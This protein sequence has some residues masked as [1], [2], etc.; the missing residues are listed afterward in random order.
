MEEV[1]INDKENDNDNSN[2]SA[3][4]DNSGIE[5]DTKYI[6]FIESHNSSQE[7]KV[8]LSP[9]YQEANSLKCVEELELDKDTD[10]YITSIYRFKIYNLI[11]ENEILKIIAED[12]NQEKIEVELSKLKPEKNVFLFDLNSNLNIYD[13]KLNV[14]EELDIYDNYLRNNLELE[15]DSKEY[16]DLITSVLNYI[17]DNNNNKIDFSFYISILLVTFNTQY[18]IDLLELFCYERIREQNEIPSKYIDEF[19]MNINIFENDVFIKSIEDKNKNE[20]LTINLCTIIYYFC[21]KYNKKKI[22]SFVKKENSMYIYK[23]LIKHRKFFLKVKLSKKII[24]S[25]IKNVNSYND[26]F[27]A[28]SYNRDCLT[29]LELINENIDSCNELLTREKDSL[30]RLDLLIEPKREDDLKKI[31]DEILDLYSNEKKF[32]KKF[33]K[34]SP[35]IFDKYISFFMDDNEKINLLNKMINDVKVTEQDF[36]IKNDL[37]FITHEKNIELAKEHKLNNFEILNIIKN[38]KFYNDDQYNSEKFRSPEILSGIDVYQINQEFIAKWKEIDFVKIFDINYY[39]YAKQICKLIPNISYFGLLFELL[40]KGKQNEFYKFDYNSISLMQYTFETLLYTYIPENCLN[41]KNDVINLIYYSDQVKFKINKLL[42]EEIEL[43][44]NSN[45]ISEIYSIVLQRHETL[46]IETL[47]IILEYFTQNNWNTNYANIMNLI[48]LS[49]KIKK[50]MLDKLDKYIIQENE[51]FEIEET[52]N[53]KLLLELIKIYNENK[54]EGGKYFEKTMIVISEL[55]EKIKNLDI[56]YNLITYFIDNKKED[57]LYDRL[58]TIFLL[59]K[60]DADEQKELLIK[61][62]K[63]IKLALNNLQTYLDKVSLF[64]PN[65]YFIEIRDL[66]EVINK[67]KLGTIKK[68]LKEYSYEYNKYTTKL[69][70]DI[71]RIGKCSESYF[72][73]TIYNDVKNKYKLDDEKCFKKAIKHFE[74]LKDI[75]SKNKLE[76]SNE[77]IVENCLKAFIDKEEELKKEI[78]IDIEL[79]KLTSIKDKFRLHQ[80][81]L[82]LLKRKKILDLINS[83]QLFISQLGLIRTDFSK[84]LDNI[85]KK[86][87]LNK[88]KNIKKATDILAKY[89][90]KIEDKLE[91]YLNI[92]LLFKEERSSLDFLF[93]TSIQDCQVLQEL[94]GVFD[95]GFL[96]PDDIINLE[97]CINFMAKFGNIQT[98]RAIKDIDM[99]NKFKNEISKQKNISVYFTKYINNFPLLNDMMT[100]GLDRAEMSKNKVSLIL[101]KSEFTITNKKDKFFN[102]LYFEK[103][104]NIQNDL[105]PSNLKLKDLF[106]LR[107]RAQL[108]R[109]MIIQEKDNAQEKE[110]AILGNQKFI[111]LVSEINNLYG[112]LQDI[113]WKGF[114][115][116]VIVRINID[117]NN[118]IYNV[119]NK[120]YSSFDEIIKIIK[121]IL[122]KINEEQILGYKNKKLIRYFFGLQF[123][124]FYKII[125]EPRQKH[126]NELMPF[127]KYCT[128]E[129][130]IDNL[131]SFSYK[132]SKNIYKDIISNCERYLK[133]ILKKNEITFQKIYSFSIIYQKAKLGKYKGI[134]TYLS[135][136]LEKDLFQ[137]YK[138]FTKRDPVA[139][140]ILLCNKDTTSE[141]IIA[142]LYRAI[143]CEFNSCFIMGGVESLIFE[144]KTNFFN[145]ISSLYVENYRKMRSCLI[146]LYTNKTSD[147]YKWLDLERT[148]KKL[149]ISKEAY[150]NER[151]EGNEIEII[152][153]DR[154]GVGKSAQI[155]N[156]ILIKGKKYV[157]FPL[158]GVLI[159]DQILSRLKKLELD[160]NCVVH[161]DLYDTDQISLMMEFLFSVLVTKLYGKNENIFY[162]SKFLEVKIEIP[163]SFIDF[164]A[165]FPILNLFKKKMLSIDNLAPLIVSQELTSNIQIVCNYLKELKEYNINKR[166]LFFPGITPEIVKETIFIGKKDAKT[167]FV[168]AVDATVLSQNE[169]QRLIFDIIKTRIEK[170]T[171]YQINSFIDILAEQLRKFNQNYYLSSRQLRIAKIPNI[172]KFILESFINITKH[173]TEGAFTELLKRQ[174]QTHKVITGQYNEEQ[175]INDAINNLALNNNN[176]NIVSFDK[177]DPSLLFFHEGE[178]QSFSIITN[179]NKT[180]KEYIDLLALQNSQARIKKDLLKELPNYKNYTQKQ[181]LEELKAIL[182]IKNPVEK[183]SSDKRKSLE[184]I[185]GN[186]VFTADNFVKMALILLRIRS[187]IPV[188]MMGETGC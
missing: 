3:I 25:M 143:L 79:L 102:C 166:D 170:P 177:I 64:F 153:S 45:L 107:D 164:F 117:N 17:H 56:N 73:I 93:Y 20:Q 41:F 59:D 111:K 48:K 139:Q 28:I 175:D 75:F 136:N 67:I 97:N 88:V 145:L 85:V 58:F 44:L 57:L 161:L 21:Y 154:S 31:Y 108:N 116:E 101:E 5:E 174:E 130:I 26:L 9:N 112:L 119:D 128:N 134:Y 104:R 4:S 110:N 94:P 168:T 70:E 91:D 181:F 49:P 36:E 81:L 66:R 63:V 37:E 42:K 129:L 23:G 109:T 121:D 151:Y 39:E 90:I 27:K 43:N 18:F 141:E 146:I 126:L 173:F 171:Y 16:E 89:E 142:F 114:T 138:Y 106:D 52:N 50:L 156:D 188:I 51:F 14:Y 32:N 186:Y 34:M 24:S 71:E 178:G 68:Y 10:I 172:R 15:K 159:R 185:A 169:C 120:T 158:G 30:I 13:S 8:Y 144:K 22:K 118:I 62:V 115:N 6:F 87:Q 157:Y 19:N 149:D 60:Y 140:N 113:Y 2:N 122:Q 11:K 29:L 82:L 167:K 152:Y 187:N 131:D 96:T 72:F 83:L 183:N 180:D 46:S 182:D 84:D 135:E 127:L 65:K 162:L 125:N 69:R 179:K 12:K 160:N 155:K 76:D 137:I 132:K 147:V 123:N 124:Y 77:N 35:K 33:V 133:E 165:K 176:K 86:T 38:D 54:N 105:I 184:E 53:Y 99:V 98:I 100:N 1:E 74:K 61:N 103:K 78:D 163:N 92:I 40:N 55:T 7:I 47:N 80:D 148:I 150:E 95:N